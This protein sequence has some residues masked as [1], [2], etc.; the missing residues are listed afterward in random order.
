[1]RVLL[2]NYFESVHC[3]SVVLYEPKFRT[4]FESVCDEHTR[5]SQKPFLLLLST[6][7]GIAAW[8][9]SKRPSS[10]LQETDVDWSAW[11]SNLIKYTE[12]QLFDII[13][14]STLANIQTCNLL[15]SYNSYHGKPKSAF[16]LLGAMI[17]TAQAMGL[18][19][20]RRF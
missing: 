8:Y 1:M 2:E 10:A 7:L 14:Q 9:Y 5:P 12:S 15:A 17:K 20:E 6:V 19:R 4:Q 11:A 3:F 18:H 13:D 16:A